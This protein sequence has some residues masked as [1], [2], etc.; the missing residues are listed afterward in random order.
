M[1]QTSDGHVPLSGPS[2]DPVLYG[3]ANALSQMFPLVEHTSSLEDN[4]ATAEA[5]HVGCDQ[6]TE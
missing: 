3:V 1:M 5:G 2:S 6:N 4:D